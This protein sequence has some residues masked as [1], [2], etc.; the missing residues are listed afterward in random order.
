MESHGK[1][2][3]NEVVAVIPARYSSVRLAGKMLL[4]LAGKPLVVHTLE[5]AAQSKLVTRIVAATDDERIAQVV[6]AAGFEVVMTSSS[7]E[8]GSD[9]VAEVARSLSSDSI[10]V[11]VQ[12]DEPL[13]TGRIVDAA[14]DALINDAEADIATTYE[15]FKNWEDVLS[16]DVVKVVL[17]GKG[18]ASY[19]S[20]SPIPFLRDASKENGSLAA[21]L[22]ADPG[23][24]SNFKRHQGIY[25]YRRDYLIRFSEMPKSVL[26]TLEMLEQLRALEAGAKIKVV[27]VDDTSIGVD[28]QSDFEKVQAMLDAA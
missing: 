20:R 13:M 7:H 8:S 21:A 14:V 2:P 1:N 10:V 3:E 17:D 28:T 5:G 4:P 16:P 23:L 27:K 12:G 24:L 15:S 11:N 26:E 9:R 22:K 25:A 19:F 18:H 6:H